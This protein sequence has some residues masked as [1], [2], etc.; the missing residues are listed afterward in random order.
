MFIDSHREVSVGLTHAIL[1]ALRM[2]GVANPEALLPEAGIDPDL[3]AKPENRIP[4]ERQNALWALAVS[5]APEP[6]FGLQFARSVQPTSF[7]VVGYMAM[8]CG[9]IG[10]CLEAI[11]DYQFLAGEGGEFSLEPC[12][13]DTA[14]CYNPVNPDDP[15]TRERVVGMLAATVS[16]GR[17]LVGRAFQPQRVAF[18]H[19]APGETAEYDEFFGCTVRFGDARNCAVYPPAVT[20]LVVPT[21]S[22]DLLALLRERANRMLEE[23]SRGGIAS[24]IASLLASQLDSAVP[25]KAVIAAQLG[26]SERTLQRRLREEGTTYQATLDRTRHYLARDLLRNTQMS[27]AEVAVQLGFSEPSTF[28][29]AFKRWEGATPGQY[30]ELG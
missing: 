4:F 30:R 27:L 25:D 6:A 12:G 26:M 3:L 24:R 29:R 20:G 2:E 28:F 5:S 23:L 11:V 22:E 17:W 8:N 10:E 1:E 15:V 16:F 13:S 18:T 14:L 7:G 9:S 19:E 21:A